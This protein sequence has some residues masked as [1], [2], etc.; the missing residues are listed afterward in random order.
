M[1]VEESFNRLVQMASGTVVALVHKGE[2][3]LLSRGMLEAAG[4]IFGREA[5]LGALS[6]GTG[7]LEGKQVGMSDSRGYAFVDAVAD[8]PVFIQRQAFLQVCGKP[9]ID[10]P[11]YPRLAIGS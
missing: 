9:V 4:Y 11:D 5:G 10:Q 2:E 3:H 1:T 6:F 8:G 7:W